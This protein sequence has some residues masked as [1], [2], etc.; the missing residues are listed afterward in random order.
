MQA[1]FLSVKLKQLDK[2]NQERRRIAGR[3]LSEIHN[4][5]IALPCRSDSS[6]EHIYH[7][8]VIRCRERDSLE[9]YLK[10]RGIGTLKHYPIPMHLQGA[11]ADLNIRKGDLPIAEE[12]SE[13]VL[14]I[15]MYYGMSDE[16]ISYVIEVINR[17]GD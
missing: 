2:W 7:V 1:A 11:Y 3:Y 16:D 17:Y 4:P 15:P 8:F 14:S 9:K 5:L 13:T 12:I 10:E 6:F